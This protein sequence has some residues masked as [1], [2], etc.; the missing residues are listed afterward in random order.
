MKSLNLYPLCF[1]PL[2]VAPS[3]HTWTED[4]TTSHVQV[5]ESALKSHRD[6]LKEARD[7]E[8]DAEYIPDINREL[9]TVNHLLNLLW[10]TT[11]AHDETLSCPFTDN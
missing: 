10:Q 1:L 7:A 5:L 9:A 3:E 8:P 4:P 6:M 2:Q 11:K